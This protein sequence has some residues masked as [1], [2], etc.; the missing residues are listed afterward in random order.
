M[1]SWH[2]TRPYRDGGVVIVDRATIIGCIAHLIGTQ[3]TSTVVWLIQR[4]SALLASNVARK[5]NSCLQG[6]PFREISW[7]L[8]LQEA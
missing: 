1:I 3:S 7:I 8:G 6:Y 4:L 5:I 2:T